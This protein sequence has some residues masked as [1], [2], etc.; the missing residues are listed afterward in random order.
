LVRMEQ[1]PS[2]I[3]TQMIEK[4]SRPDR[5]CGAKRCRC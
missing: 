1:Y 5:I 2:R 3:S 4:A